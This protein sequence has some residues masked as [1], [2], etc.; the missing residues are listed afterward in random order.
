[1]APGSIG[2]HLLAMICD[3]FNMKLSSQNTEYSERRKIIFGDIF[4]WF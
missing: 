3:R 1:M 4:E 2:N